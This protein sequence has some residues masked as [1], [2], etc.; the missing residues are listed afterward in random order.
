MEGEFD[1][2]L[3]VVVIIVD[4]DEGNSGSINYVRRQLVP[5]D[6]FPSSLVYMVVYLSGPS[7]TIAKNAELL[8]RSMIRGNWK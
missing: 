3:S 4:D 5:S 6:K 1:A 2:N 8:G 7:Q